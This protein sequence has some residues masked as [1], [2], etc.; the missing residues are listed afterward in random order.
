M[1]SPRLTAALCSCFRCSIF[2][3]S[4]LCSRGGSPYM[5]FCRWHSCVLLVLR[6]LC[7]EKGWIVEYCWIGTLD[8]C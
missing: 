1:M 5:V 4:L 6:G 8:E 3:A 2:Y 7:G